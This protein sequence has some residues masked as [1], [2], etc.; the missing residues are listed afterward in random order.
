MSC[1]TCDKIGAPVEG[2][3]MMCPSCFGVFCLGHSGNH[4]CE[5]DPT[6]TAKRCAVCGG[7]NPGDQSHARCQ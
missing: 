6:N 4:G 7:L 3:T 1:V 2:M 5:S